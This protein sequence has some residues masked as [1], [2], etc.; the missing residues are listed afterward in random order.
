MDVFQKAQRSYVMSLIRAKDTK[1]EMAVRKILHSEGFRYRLH[2]PGLPGKPDIVLRRFRVAIQVHGCFWH[3][4]K[5]KVSHT[6]ATKKKYW[7]PKISGN[8]ARDLRNNRRL[9]SEGW[10]LFVIWE[11]ESRKPKNLKAKMAK[12]LTY[13]RHQQNRAT[14]HT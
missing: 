13:L 9:R 1:P 10:K 5:C 8:I 11:C 3:G 2:V 12:I 7:G 14:G 4:H 6:P